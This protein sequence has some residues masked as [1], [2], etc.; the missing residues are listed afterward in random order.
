MPLTRKHN[1]LSKYDYSQPNY[2]FITTCTEN[3][4][5]WFGEI[6]NNKMILNLYG[7]ICGPCLNFLPQHYN[8]PK[9]D[10]FIINNSIR[11]NDKFWEGYKPSPTYSNY[12]LTEIIRG[13]KTFSLKQINQ[14]ISSGNKFKLRDGDSPRSHVYSRAFLRSKNSTDC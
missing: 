11:D 3:H 6:Q 13:F 8:N 4:K 14:T 5:E 7:E 1:R 10:I 2:Y 9:I 12:S